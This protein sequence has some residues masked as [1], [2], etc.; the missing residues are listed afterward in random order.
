[1]R[2]FFNVFHSADPLGYRL[3]DILL[4]TGCVTP[5]PLDTTASGETLGSTTS[6]K[7]HP[8][9]PQPLSVASSRSSVLDSPCAEVVAYEL[10][11]D[12]PLYRQFPYGTED[13]GP[14]YCCEKESGV[15]TG[16]ANDAALQW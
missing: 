13:P 11:F 2:Q 12:I 15:M 10:P 5:T 4:R 14:A 16:K 1:C 8:S 3:E 6:F 9:Q 7:L